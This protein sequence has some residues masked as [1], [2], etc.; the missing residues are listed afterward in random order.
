MSEINT[1]YIFGHK[2]PDSDSV[3][4]AI[5]LSHLKNKLNLN[6]KPFTLGKINK[7]TEFILNKFSLEIPEIL[8]NIQIEVKDLNYDYI[9][10]IK[11][12]ISILEA[13]NIMKNS[14]IRTL[15]VVNNENKLVGIL[16]MKDIAIDFIS[17]NDRR[18]DTSIENIVSSLNGKLL[19]KRHGNVLGEILVIALYHKTLEKKNLVT[20]NTVA[21]VGDNY[22][23]IEF[24]ISKNVNSIIVTGGKEPPKHYINK[25]NENN[26][27]II[28][29][30]I[31]TYETSRRLT[32]CNKVSAIMVSKNIIRF[33]PHYTIDDVKE[34]M[35]LY[36][37][38]N[39]PV[40]AKGKKYLGMLNRNHIIT[41]NKK[42]V[43]LVDHNEYAQSVTGL[44]NANIL[45][46]IDHHK[47]GD[48]NTNSPI[49]FKNIPVGS[50][51]TIVYSIYKEN[52]IDIPKNIAGILISGI[53]SDTL[54][55]KSPTT[56]EF[57]KI[58]ADELNKI[59]NLDLDKYAHEM[60]K[61]GSSLEG[62]KIDEIL[63][64]DYKEFEIEGLKIGI[65][66]IFTLNI[67]DILNKKDEFLEC[68]NT[69]HTQK[70][71]D[72]TL[73]V[74]T[75]ILS[76]GS[77]FLYVTNNTNIIKFMLNGNL[78]Q[79]YFSKGIISRKKQIVPL[80]GEAI[81]SQKNM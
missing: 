26:I 12:Y 16:T 78:E 17:G 75:D 80:I 20:E 59:L 81:N 43:I 73:L 9:E 67:E 76:E 10:P 1:I 11:P 2:N 5:A 36:K 61:Y 65:A 46:I 60:F 7:E 39:Y 42:D 27:N 35:S 56:T 14:Q 54:L 64:K 23:A 33:K 8:K 77:H 25:A 21:I 15:P 3:C 68:L 72:I 38:T 66:Q 28:S 69:N 57:D 70:S 32:L 40:V 63:N 13:Y 79:G 6:A 52:N 29:V 44:K 24:L 37:Y 49:L 71:N 50:T 41:P 48:I 30:N 53:I 22:E 47:I 58:A 62:Q 18:L 45:E 74:A 34:D 4:S 31:D 55:F 51:C 19:T